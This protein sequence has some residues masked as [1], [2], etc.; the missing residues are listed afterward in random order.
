MERKPKNLE[1]CDD[2]L[3]RAEALERDLKRLANA[4]PPGVSNLRDYIIKTSDCQGVVVSRLN[5]TYN[6][7]RRYDHG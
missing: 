1:T 7:I 2:L 3:S 4:M 5:T 6:S